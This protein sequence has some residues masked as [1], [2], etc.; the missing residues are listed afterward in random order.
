MSK[1]AFLKPILLKIADRFILF[2]GLFTLLLFIL[3]FTP[4]PY[5]AYHWL[6]VANAELEK[7]PNLIV[8]L[9]GSGMPSPDGLI[10][11]YYG[12]EAA[13]QYKKA[14]IIIALPYNR[15]KDSLY[16]LNLMSHELIIR[17]IDSTRI[18]YE[19]I[20]FS[21]H[22][23]ARNIY[24]NYR[25][26][27]QNLSLLLVT[28]PEHMYRA[29]GTFKKAG[30]INVGGVPSFG[31]NLDEDN[32]KDKDKNK[33][34]RIKSLALRYNVWSYLNYE[35]LVLRETIAILYYKLKGWM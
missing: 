13:K 8:I 11:T 17:G 12:A 3:S 18:H 2:T 32:V 30:F 28:S 23:Q 7:Q 24:N 20:G 4:L 26:Q 10:R 27:V 21:T 14:E 9:G 33:D 15:E 1:T 6:G 34:S 5:Y 29:V 19:P 25:N 16:Q 22:T 35:L 31:E